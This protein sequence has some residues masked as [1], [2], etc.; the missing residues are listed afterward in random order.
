[1]TGPVDVAAPLDDSPSIVKGWIAI[2]GGIAAWAVHIVAS[3]SLV[4]LACE[5]RAE[6]PLHA[7]TAVCVVGAL[8]A[9]VVAIRL[10]RT[11]SPPWRFVGWVGVISSLAN[12]LLILLEGSYV[13]FLK[14]CA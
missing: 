11:P 6:W 9:L 2:G 1:M 8:A 12:L 14:P 3:A 10:T 4:D 13:L 7:L 5:K